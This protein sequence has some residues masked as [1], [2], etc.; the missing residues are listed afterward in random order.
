M[1]IHSK[2]FTTTDAIKNEPFTALVE[3][4]NPKDGKTF[5]V[6]E[7]LE[8]G[9]KT[10]EKFMDARENTI[11]GW[12]KGSTPDKG[13]PMLYSSIAM[14]VPGAHKLVDALNEVLAASEEFA[15]AN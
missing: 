10:R 7:A 8:G 12:E 13:Q 5:V 2:I 3:T 6:I 1:E 4:I 11:Q 9:Y 15:S 14:M